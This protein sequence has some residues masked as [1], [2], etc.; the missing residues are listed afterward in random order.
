MATTGS[1]IQRQDIVNDFN[2]I[3][4]QGI[5]YKYSSTLLPSPPPEYS[6]TTP[7]DN[8]GSGNVRSI[9]LND[10]TNEGVISAST[11][12]NDLRSFVQTYYSQIRNI[13]IVL[14]NKGEATNVVDTIYEKA[15]LTDAYKQQVPSFSL[16]I[17]TNQLIKASPQ[18]ENILATWRDIANNTAFTITYYHYVS[19][20]SHGSRVRR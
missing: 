2:D 16:G 15:Y 1:L 5:S 7:T 17:S 19:H 20:V 6:G 4:K 11:L 13:E 10:I 14:K 9:S 8:F 3:V 18:Y 12:L